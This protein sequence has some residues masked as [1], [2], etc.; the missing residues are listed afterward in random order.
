MIIE[1]RLLRNLDY[2]LLATVLG[3]LAVGLLAVYS[4]TQPA[5]LGGP[6]FNALV[7]RQVVGA[8]T[9]LL[10]MAVMIVVDYR[11]WE[12]WTTPLYI[13]SLLLLVAVL[14]LGREVNGSKSWLYL[15]PL[16]SF[17]PS[18]LVKVL[19]VVGLAGMLAEKRD[20]STPRSLVLPVLF[21]AVPMMLILLEKDLGTALVFVGVLL[22][23][24]LVA[25]A[26]IR[27]LLWA[28][29]AG[30]AA[31]PLV[32]FFVLQPYQRARL[33]VLFNPQA[34][35]LQAGY[36]VV[37]AMIAIGSGRL[38]GKGLFSGSQTQ[39]NFVPEHHT[40]FIFSVIGEEF[41][42]LGAAAVLAGYFYLIWKGI[43]IAGEARDRFGALLVV[44]L[45]SILLVH[46]VVNV[47]MNL[48]VVPVTGIPLPFISYGSSALVSNLMAAGL[49]LNVG[50]RR[51][52]ILF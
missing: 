31:S 39:L 16:G 22:A 30:V 9:G 25:G 8:A 7:L 33:L 45:E 4:A 13:F 52:K 5:R 19:V 35:Q 1:K 29:G 21:V 51:Q 24:L 50:M 38:F 26:P 17:Q 14:V 47:G 37:Q 43:Q 48:G 20:L 15:G 41:G 49:I 12:K 2:P 27:Y 34:Y 23:M 10:A 36:N 32:F 3:L 11:V 42:F 46:I 44:G 6:G 28:I 18:E 40:D